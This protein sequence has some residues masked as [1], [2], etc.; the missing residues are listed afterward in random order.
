MGD[1]SPSSARAAPPWPSTESTT[2]T[3]PPQRDEGR[4]K[5]DPDHDDWA[6]F[7]AVTPGLT[8]GDGLVPVLDFGTMANAAL[9]PDDQDVLVARGYPKATSNIAYDAQ[10]IRWQAF[11]AS[12][13][14][15][16]RPDWSDACHTMR[17]DDVTQ[18]ESIDGM[19][20]SPIFLLKP[21]TPEQFECSFAGM[22]LRGS[23]TSRLLHFLDASI[24]RAAII[25]AHRLR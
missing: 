3:R 22:A 13:K 15:A 2:R 24:I 17:L 8:D 21:R 18:I 25:A 23:K 7:T 9:P 12:G 14:Y 6:V 20:G 5:D 10:A 19:S 1:A 16:G 11:G 4:H